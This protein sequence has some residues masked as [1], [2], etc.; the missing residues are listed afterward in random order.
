MN[1]P[2]DHRHEHLPPEL[3]AATKEYVEWSQ[4][5]L[6]IE[7]KE[8]T[9]VEPLYHYTDVKALRGILAKQQ[10]WCF[11]HLHQRDRTEFGY[12]LAIAR[13]VIKEV[14]LTDDFFSHHFCGCLD[15][16][17]ETNSLVDAFEFYLF[18]LSRHC[19]DLRQWMEY[20][21]QGHGI[22]IAFAPVLFQPDQTELSE[23]ASA[24]LHVGRVIYGDG[25]TEERHRRAV[26]RAAQ[27]TSRVANA[28]LNAVKPIALSYLAAMAKQLIASQL[29][30]NCLT[31]KSIGYQN[32]REVRY[33]IMNVPGKFDGLRKPL[34]DKYYIE[35]DVP[36]KTAGNIKEIL[37]GPMASAATEAMVAGLLNEFGYPYGIPIRRSA[38]SPWRLRFYQLGQF[39]KR[40]GLSLST[41]S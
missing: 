38:V 15:D 17:L 35:A 4:A 32:E 40:I 36:L 22:A 9:P 31:A 34:G 13:R 1:K 6:L 18:S 29:V 23:K 16:L 19:D 14:G 7:Q 37:I 10:V 25:P 28:N 5:Q 3:E 21:D 33:V 27:I 20:G 12:S 8:S 39:L 41:R 11:R 26:E 2:D 24:N 30:W